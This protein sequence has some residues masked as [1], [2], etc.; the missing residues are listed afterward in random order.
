MDDGGLY[1]D[2]VYDGGGLRAHGLTHQ[3]VW[4]RARDVVSGAGERGRA[5]GAA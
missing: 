1:A 2:T 3:D 4:S 5:G